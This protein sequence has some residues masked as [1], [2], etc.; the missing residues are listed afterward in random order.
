MFDVP[1]DWV[2]N[3]ESSDGLMMHNAK[4]EVSQLAKHIVDMDSIVA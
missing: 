1:C 4:A 3:D 2:R